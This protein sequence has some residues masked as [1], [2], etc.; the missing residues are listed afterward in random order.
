MHASHAMP[1]E[2]AAAFFA[3]LAAR[4]HEPG[5][6]DATGSWEFEIEGVGTWTVA[7]N[8]GTLS[9]SHGAPPAAAQA[10]TRTRLRM[11]ED[12]LLRLVHGD[13]HENLFMGVIR[14][15]IMI[16]GALAFG[17]RLQAILPFSDERSAP[18]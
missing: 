15:S 7:V 14:G 3:A 8:H 5:L 4:A 13:G 6:A 16:E 9:V 10:A 12:E 17:Q 18:T 2:S 1:I 11:R